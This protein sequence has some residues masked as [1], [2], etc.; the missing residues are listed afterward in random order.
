[1]KN[2]SDEQYSLMFRLKRGLVWQWGVNQADDSVLRF[3][4]DDG[5]AEAHC[6]YG[7]DW[8]ALSQQGLAMLSSYEQMCKQ[9]ADEDAKQRSEEA[10]R[11]I[12]IKQSRKHDYAVVAF[13]VALSLFLEHIVDIINFLKSLF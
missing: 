9:C 4:V 7:C 6:E 8:Y 10:K 5:V 11:I 2:Y 1:M 12:D 13:S 3:L